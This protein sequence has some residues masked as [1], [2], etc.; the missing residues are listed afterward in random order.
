[1]RWV[2][3]VATSTV[4]KQ[5]DTAARVLC[6]GMPAVT[7]WQ[8]APPSTAQ[9]HKHVVRAHHYHGGGCPL[10]VMAAGMWGTQVP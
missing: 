7:C 6:G 8:Q 5:P 10:H 1:M 4:N 3:S 2:R 9:G